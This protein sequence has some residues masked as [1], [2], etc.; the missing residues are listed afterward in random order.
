MSELTPSGAAP[1]LRG[2]NWRRGGRWVLRD[3]D[4][5]LHEPRIALIGDNGAG[6]S[7]LFRLLSGLDQPD[8]GEIHFAPPPRDASV[9]VC[10]GLG[11]MFQSSEDQIIFPTVEEELALSLSPW[12][13]QRAQAL[14]QAREWLF[15][16]G[17]GEWASRG[18]GSLSQGQR[19]YVCWLALRIAPHRTLLLDE[20]FA[21]LDLPAQWR[22]RREFAAVPQQLVV[23]THLLS[24]VQDFDRVI[25]L[26]AGR[27]RADGVPAEVCAAYEAE[28]AARPL[29]DAQ[30]ARE[31]A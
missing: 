10:N 8:S 31:S 29:R 17:L 20:P 22:L 18:M 16:Q 21:S 13:P 12:V 15:T 28:V 26:E 11:L 27:V 1:Q 7:S 14:A 24:H 3:I 6:K 4:L 9:T 5:W 2:V 23:S 25:W 19:Q 30:S